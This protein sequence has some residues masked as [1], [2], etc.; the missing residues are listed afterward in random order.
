MS[1]AEHE[2]RADHEQ[3]GKHDVRVRIGDAG[4]DG[5]VLEQLLETADINAHRQDQQQ[6]R[7]RDGEPAPGQREIAV[8]A[9]GERPGCRR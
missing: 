2:R 5:V 8:A 9:S 1:R 6:E 7:K 4:E 3:A